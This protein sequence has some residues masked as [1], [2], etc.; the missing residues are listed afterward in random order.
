MHGK[1]WKIRYTA[2]II[3]KTSIKKKLKAK[4]NNTSKR[5]HCS[6]RSIDILYLKKKM[7]IKREC[8]VNKLLLP[9]DDEEQFK[10]VVN[11][12]SATIKNKFIFNLKK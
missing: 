3:L 11:L 1:W 10:V 7:W 5:H 12:T 9:V 6:E 8:W 2:G 4:S